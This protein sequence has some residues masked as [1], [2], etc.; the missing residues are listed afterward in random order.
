MNISLRNGAVFLASI[1]VFARVASGGVIGGEAAV[2]SWQSAGAG[3]DLMAGWTFS[4]NTDVVVTA[5]GMFDHHNPNGLDGAHDVVIWDSN[6]QIIVSA[7]IPSGTVAERINQT[8]Y[9]DVAPVVLPSGQEFLIAA[10]YIGSATADWYAY[11][12]F[13]LGFDPSITF[14]EGR[15]LNTSDF[16]PPTNPYERP[17]I[18]PNFLIQQVP[19]PT[20]LALLASAVVG[21]A[22]LSRRKKVNAAST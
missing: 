1:V 11:N 16:I 13:T 7:T 12:Y 4:T 22:F 15:S 17:F 20:S 6:N 8:R 19:E 14:I 5:L 18:G 21:L 3:T 9:V 10:Q 2:Y